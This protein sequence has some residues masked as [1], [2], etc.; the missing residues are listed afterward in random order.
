[1]RRL[2]ALVLLLTALGAGAASAQQTPAQLIAQARAKFDE[3]QPESA[4]ALLERVLSPNSG[5]TPQQQVRAWVLYGISQLWRDN[6]AAAQQAFRQ[7]L[8]REPTLRVD[9]LEFLHE[10]VRAAFNAERI[11]VAPAPAAPGPAAPVVVRLTVT[12]EV[13]RDTT[14][15]A[16]G[17]L[18]PIT[19]VPSRQARGMVTVSPAEAPTVIVWG[20]TLPAGAAGA[21]GWNLH[22]QNGNVVSSGRYTLRV[23][24]MD[25]VGEVSPTIE[26]VLV[27]ARTEAD[28]QPLPPSLAPSAF[29][30]ET[31]PLKRAS[32]SVLLI[33]AGF[34]AAAALLPSALGRTELSQG[35]SG[36]GTAY[37]VAAS[38]TAAGLA[39]FLGG[40]RVQPMPENALRNAELRQRDEA[41]RAAIRTANALARES[42]PVRVRLEGAGP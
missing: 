12:A 35:L 16:E 34:G 24:A 31:R 17:N 14:L 30:P 37:V 26:R 42:A 11:I 39:G 25:S 4:Q 23:T 29:E 20:D 5:A 8:Q 7:A 2:L 27:V 1:V 3:F 13:P 6:A 21:L 33:G 38:V 36:D 15:S 28:T 10:N 19:L 41:S 40:H 32:P 18:L 9:T 22:D